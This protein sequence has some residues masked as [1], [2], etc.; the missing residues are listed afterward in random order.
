MSTPL[1]LDVTRLSLGV[2]KMVFLWYNKSSNKREVNIMKFYWYI[3]SDGYRTC[4]Q[5]VDQ[6]EMSH[7]VAQHGRLLC[8]IPA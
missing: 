7:L 3:F 5:G 6:T 1:S 4:V 8:K 2:D